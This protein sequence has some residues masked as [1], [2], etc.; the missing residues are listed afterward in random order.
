[1]LREEPLDCWAWLLGGAVGVM[2]MVRRTPVTV[3]TD[4]MGVGVHVM[5]ESA[6]ERVEGALVVAL[7]PYGDVSSDQAWIL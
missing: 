3:S 2:V 7:E 5:V 6:V 1:V 4:V